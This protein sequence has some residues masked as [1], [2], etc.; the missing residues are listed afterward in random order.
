MGVTLKME[1]DATIHKLHCVA[2]PALTSS[3]V[4]LVNIA[5]LVWTSFQHVVP[6][7]ELE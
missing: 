5:A 3:S 6:I 7:A 1:E 4:T 2:H